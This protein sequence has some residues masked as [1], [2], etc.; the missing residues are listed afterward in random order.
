MSVQFQIKQ[1]KRYT[2]A[3][4]IQ[5][6]Y[7]VDLMGHWLVDPSVKLICTQDTA[8][9][10]TERFGRVIIKSLVS[11]FGSPAVLFCSCILHSSR[12]TDNEARGK[13][14][15]EDMGRVGTDMG[16]RVEHAGIP[17]ATPGRRRQTDRQ[18]D[19]GGTTCCCWTWH[20]APVS[21]GG[22]Q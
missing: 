20:S 11:D 18:N 3:T 5:K 2:L 15:M 22:A 10:Q 6:H 19:R 12:G 13:G 17:L 21:A 8:S 16:M 14:M 9:S 4:C 7:S 1:M